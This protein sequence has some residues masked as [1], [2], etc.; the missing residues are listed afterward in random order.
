MLGHEQF[1]HSS[2]TSDEKLLQRRLL[3]CKIHLLQYNFESKNYYI[4]PLKNSFDTNCFN[5]GTKKE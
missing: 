2:K 3:P 1:L 4:S 5:A